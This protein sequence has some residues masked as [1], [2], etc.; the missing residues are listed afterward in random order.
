MNH[1]CG[2]R[3]SDGGRHRGRGSRGKSRDCRSAALQR[4]EVRGGAGRADRERK[5]HECETVRDVL[6]LFSDDRASRAVG[7]VLLDLGAI[8]VADR[9]AS[10]GAE[11]FD[12]P[13]AG[14]SVVQA[15]QVSG[16]PCLAQALAS[17]RR[18]LGDRHGLHSQQGCDRRRLHLLDLGV[19][20]HLLPPGRQTPERTMRQ[21]AIERLLGGLLRGIGIG[22][23]VEILDRGVVLGA[24]PAGRGVAD[25][26]EQV[27]AEGTGGSAT[28]ADRLE[29]AGVCLLHKIVGI[30]LRR[31][32][33][34]DVHAGG[35]VPLPQ[36]RVGLRV[37]LAGAFNQRRIGYGVRGHGIFGVH[38]G[39]RSGRKRPATT[40]PL[41][42]SR[43]KS[44][45]R[46]V[47][48]SVF[49]PLH[50]RLRTSPRFARSVIA[51]ARRSPLG[52]CQRDDE[53]IPATR[54]TAGVVL[55]ARDVASHA[56]T[57]H[58]TGA[59]VHLAHHCD[60]R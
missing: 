34:S 49:V 16:D 7:Q 55:T 5:Q 59:G 13:L 47:C 42:Y 31:D 2:H 20:E 35:V 40:R 29:D 8:A 4:G 43:A 17:A 50:G 57:T 60:A 22:D 6:C 18:E 37:A 46:P 32:G 15:R 9:A 48:G 21:S 51:R 24:A 11:A 3:R 12:D 23:G 54:I 27:R 53:V 56:A 38:S 19:P 25:A 52:E 36:L 58:E 1:G 14:G 10:I 41:G 28:A 44:P 45:A 39:F 33:A 30:D 26:G